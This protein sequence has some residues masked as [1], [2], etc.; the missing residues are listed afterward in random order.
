MGGDVPITPE[1]VVEHLAMLIVT[2]LRV[3]MAVYSLQVPS[4]LL[5]P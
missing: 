4:G 2:R 5:E 3:E 1:H